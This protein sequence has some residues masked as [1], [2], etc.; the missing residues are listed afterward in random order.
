MRY[1]WRDGEF[2]HPQTGEAMPIPVRNE[3]CAPRVQSD[4]SEYRSPID[5]SLISSRSAR[6][7]DLEKNDCVEVDPPK[8]KR[9]YKNPHFAQKRGLPLSEEARG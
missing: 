6:R 4:I 1:V 9:A 3:V 5:G 7:Y 2:R 8:K